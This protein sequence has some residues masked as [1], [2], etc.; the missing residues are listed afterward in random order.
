[1]L[2][3]NEVG[4]DDACV[5]STVWGVL[6]SSRRIAPIDRAARPDLVDWTELPAATQ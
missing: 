5:L 2:A 4:E 1:V 6:R 3:R